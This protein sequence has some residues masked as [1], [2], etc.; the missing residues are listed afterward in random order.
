MAWVEASKILHLRNGYFLVLGSHEQRSHCPQTMRV[1]LE[2]LW[3]SN[4]MV[5]VECQEDSFYFEVVAHGEGVNEVQVV[6]S[7]L[8][9]WVLTVRKG[10]HGMASLFADQ[11]LAD[12]GNIRQ[13]ISSLQ[14]HVLFRVNTLMT[15]TA[16]QQL[17]PLITRGK[18]QTFAK[19][20]LT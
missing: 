1:A 20:N 5:E 17:T 2:P 19:L 7:L 16:D 3:E 8:L 13:R 14:L 12:A 15:T 18:I 10:G 11:M 4:A 6:H 9:G